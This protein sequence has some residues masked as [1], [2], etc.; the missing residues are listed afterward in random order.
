MRFLLHNNLVLLL[1]S[2]FQGKEI[3]HASFSLEIT[4]TTLLLR[5]KISVSFYCCFQGDG[6]QEFC[7]TYYSL[8]NLFCLF[9]FAYICVL[10]LNHLL[11]FFRVKEGE[12]RNETVA[13]MPFLLRLGEA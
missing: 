11:L 5:N 10:N 4:C 12:N 7:F 2:I 8:R 13:K 9:V 6:D 1:F 3:T